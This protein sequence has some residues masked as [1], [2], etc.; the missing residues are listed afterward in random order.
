MGCK[1]HTEAPSGGS[2]L[3]AKVASRYCSGS[4]VRA[5]IA[6]NNG[7]MPVACIDTIKGKSSLTSTRGTWNSIIRDPV[8]LKTRKERPSCN[9]ATSIWSIPDE[10]GTPCFLWADAK[11]GGPMCCPRSRRL[12]PR[13]VHQQIGEFREITICLISSTELS[14]LSELNNRFRLGVRNHR[15]ERQGGAEGLQY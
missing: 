15:A 9:D 11:T 14:S 6:R 10:K 3:L 8:P 12:K 1:T 13:Y 7:L 4:L 2:T 5:R